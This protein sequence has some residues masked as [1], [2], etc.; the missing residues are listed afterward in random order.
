MDK[1]QTLRQRIQAAS[2]A[3]KAELVLKHASIVNVFTYEL[4]TADIAIE[5][6]YIV[7]LGQYDG[8]REVCLLYTSRCV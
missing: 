5:K 4:E 1:N 7:G 2:G 3:K 6:G 8:E